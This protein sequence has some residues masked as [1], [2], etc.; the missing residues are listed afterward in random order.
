VKVTLI[1]V[2][3]D[4]GRERL[5]SGRGPETYLEN[6][7]E[8]ALRGAGNDVEIAIVQRTAP[9]AGELE[10]VLDVNA[11]LA[12]HVWQAVAR[13]RLPLV[14]AGNCNA[15]LGCMRDWCWRGPAARRGAAS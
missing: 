6:G 5:G 2:P 15:T 12:T 14:L 4:L 11:V 10:A 1:A 9:F 3:Y 8:N 7:A 13:G